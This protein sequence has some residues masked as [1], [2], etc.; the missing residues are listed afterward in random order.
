M[1]VYWRTKKWQAADSFDLMFD[2]DTSI[3]P[4]GIHVYSISFN[5]IP[6]DVSPF[7]MFDVE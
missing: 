7:D 2:F 3:D 4:T 6:N 5:I 1:H